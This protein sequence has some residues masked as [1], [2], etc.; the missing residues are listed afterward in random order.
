MKFLPAYL[1]LLVC[2]VTG[3]LV[4]AE[5]TGD[6]ASFESVI[7]EEI[8]AMPRDVVA[9]NLGTIGTRMLLVGGLDLSGQILDS[10]YVLSEDGE[11]EA[12][13]LNHP[14]HLTAMVEVNGE[15]YLIGGYAG[16][17]LSAKVTKLTWKDGKIS[18]EALKNLPEPRTG[19][20]VAV[21]DNVI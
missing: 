19:A 13:H 6:S 17:D 10:C 9:H 8:V 11:W 18:E 12:F 1:V 14:S 2:L 3:F 20:R 16:K 15:V 21:L 5:T 4:T 7:V